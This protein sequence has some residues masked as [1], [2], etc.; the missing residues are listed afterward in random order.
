MSTHPENIQN[1]FDRFIKM[2]Q[3]IKGKNCAAALAL[4]V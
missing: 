3:D 4:L 2:I 1:H